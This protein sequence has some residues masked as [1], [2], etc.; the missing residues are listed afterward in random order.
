MK[1]KACLA[2]VASLAAT[3]VANAQS[4]LPLASHRAAYEI[5]LVDSFSARP[6]DSQTPV[7]ASGLIA[8]E[9]RGT[10][11]EG[12]ASSF[13]QLTQL[14]RSEGDPLS[15]DIR[16][17]TFEDGDAKGLKFQIDSLS[18]GSSAPAVVGSARR[19]DS[20][21]TTVALTKPSKETVNIGHDVLFPTEHIEHIIAKA[22]QGVTTLQARVYDGSDT[23][24]KVFQTLTVIGKE[25][26]GP[27]PENDFADVLGKVRRWP[28]T[29]SYFDEANKDAPPEY[30]LSFDLYENGVSGSLKLDYGSF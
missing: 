25:A 9:F 6:P 30:T 1:L 27:T 16:A 18:D 3:G 5:S 20:G 10:A 21:D 26:T 15:S 4:V 17:V 7:S 14:Q 22:K 24:K 8:Y 13:R 19:A 2:L 11:C 28:V 23:G 29:V 12:Y